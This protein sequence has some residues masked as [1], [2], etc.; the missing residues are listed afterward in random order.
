VA[1]DRHRPGGRAA[2][3]SRCR[4]HGFAL[5]VVSGLLAAVALL[6]WALTG[7]A[8]LQLRAAAWAECRSESRAR[9]QTELVRVLEEAEQ[10]G[11]E[12]VAERVGSVAEL[13]LEGL[14]AGA[15]AADQACYRMRHA[16]GQFR[17]QA[18]GPECGLQRPRVHVGGV[19]TEDW[20]EERGELHIR[21]WRWE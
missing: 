11:L 15:C 7:P 4:S 18:V 8:A 12:R 20:S 17:V 2:A 13:H 14:P 3:V 1:G 19:V 9:V 5:T 10:Q 21:W 16:R 6:A